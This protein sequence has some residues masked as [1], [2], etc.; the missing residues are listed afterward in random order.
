MP[1]NSNAE[2]PKQV[3]GLPSAAQTIWR[4][5]FNASFEKY[6]EEKALRIAWTAVKNVY[7]KKGD[8]WVKKSMLWDVVLADK[9]E[10][11]QENGNYYVEGY[12]ST[13]GLDLV[14]DYVTPECLKD[15]FEQIEIG[16]QVLAMNG[17]I[18]HEHILEDPRIMPAAKIVDKRLDDNGLWIKTMLNKY[19][20]AFKS[21]WGSIEDGFLQGFSIE[22]KPVEFNEVGEKRILNKVDL[23]GFALTGKPAC[24]GATFTDFFVK[25]KAIADE[26]AI[27]KKSHSEVNKMTETEVKQEPEAEEQEETSAEETTEETVEE[28]P[29]TE[30]TEENTEIEETA[31]ESTE[32]ETSSEEEAPAEEEAEDEGKSVTL[33]S[34]RKI[35]K[36]ELKSLQPKQKNLVAEE[37]KFETKSENGFS[38]RKSFEKSKR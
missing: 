15:M 3:K 16:E 9:F 27:K 26:I 6:G 8:E 28:T 7:R 11:K 20:A 23:G 13:T 21:I 17:G 2:L 38:F 10:I 36:E 24:P 22:F 12:L 37:E 5:A 18:E 19:H 25:S 14:D 4:K 33:K 30:K 29:S 1:Y 32:E 31:D 35:V 34:I